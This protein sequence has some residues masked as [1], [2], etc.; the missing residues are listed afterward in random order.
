ML[1]VR[2]PATCAP[3]REYA[4][5]VLL[6]CFLGLPWR[7]V[8][9]A[10]GD[11]AVALEGDATGSELAVADVLFATP[12][13]DWLTARALP[14]LPLAQWQA[15]ED[16]SLEIELPG[17]LPVVYGAADGDEP[18]WSSDGQRAWLGLD[19]FGTAFF[20]LTRY[21]ELASSER[22]KYQRFSYESSLAHRAGFLDRPV[23]NEYAEVLWAALKSLWPRLGR[24]RRQFRVVPTHDVDYPFAVYG[25]PLP[26]I[27]RKCLADVVRGR[28]LSV[29]SR[30]LSSYWRVRGGDL[31]A[32]IN[33]TFDYIMDCSERHG[34]ASTF[35]LLPYDS[36]YSLDHPWIRGLLRRIASR[37]HSFGVHPTTGT[38]RDPEGIATAAAEVRRV[39]AAEN[40]TQ[41]ELGGRQHF[42]Q[43][44][45]PTTWRAYASAGLDYDSSVG[46][47]DRAG[48][49]AGTCYPYPV[50]DL[51]QHT[52]LPLIEHPVIVMEGS[53]LQYEHLSFIAAAERIRLLK[54]RCRKVGGDF[55]LLWHN[56][57]LLTQA[58]RRLFEE[59]IAP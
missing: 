49:R 44:E 41:D 1:V 40:I 10:R 13:K 50:F 33:N 34:L 18:L 38:F 11:T 28:G 22:D 47:A 24:K 58:Q 16:L 52:R 2:C 3:E 32:D 7:M 43:W 5:E 39:L 53:L 19:I 57:M 31:G 4:C 46:F 26:Q 15:N 9:E 20:M 37:G 17:A 35:N 25:K 21:E 14:Q 45:A 29:A 23:V 6:G 8:K 59:A 54:E 36:A 12:E 30:R 55:V 42:F 51:E 48:F 56:S 27:L